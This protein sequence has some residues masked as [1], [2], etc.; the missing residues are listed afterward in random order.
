MKKSVYFLLI[1]LLA[2]VNC[3]K[4]SKDIGFDYGFDSFMGEWDLSIY[5]VGVCESVT[6][7]AIYPVPWTFDFVITDETV[8]AMSTCGLLETLL[9]HP[10]NK[11]SAW[12]YPSSSIY[13]PA[14]A[15]FN[16]E[17]C[18][19]NVAV[20]LFK[21]E[22]CFLVLASKYISFLNVDL[23]N[24]Y[25]PYISYFQIL[26]AS[27]LCM[28]SLDEIEKI[29]LTAMALERIKISIKNENHAKDTRHIMAVIMRD[30]NYAPFMEEVGAEWLDM[31]WGYQIC[32]FDV[33]EKYAI[34][35]LN[36]KI[37]KYNENI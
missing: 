36:D 1:A 4:D 15:T 35:F 20:E 27:D 10:R 13:F 17:L 33:V 32:Y 24:E 5:Q 37:Q 22:D 3:A 18:A 11:I 7:A 19:N 16:E 2:F 6:D 28:D 30:F 8:C 26:L 9:T 29:Q 23:E 31:L 12:S 25:V 21:R 14:F 34:Q